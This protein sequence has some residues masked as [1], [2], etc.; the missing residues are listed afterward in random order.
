MKIFSA[1]KDYPFRVPLRVKFFNIFRAIFTLS[2]L[3]RLLV[4]ALGSGAF[5]PWKRLVPPL[6]FYETNSI[7]EVA[8]DGI[9]YRLDI[10]RLHGH[11]IY[12]FRLRDVGWD[13]LFK[14]LKDNFYILDVGANIGYLTL[15]FARRCPNGMVYAFEP[16]SDTFTSL[17]ANVGLNNFNNVRLF[18][19][20]IGATQGT[21]ELYKMH[22]RNPGA[23]RILSEKPS[24]VRSETVDISTL[25]AHCENKSFERIDLIKIDVEGF[26][27]FVLEGAI[28]VLRQWRPMLFVELVDDNLKLQGCSGQAVVDFLKKL[29]YS[30]LDAQTMQPLV[31]SNTYYTD[32]ICCPKG[33]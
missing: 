16:D 19:T 17:S 10:S 4:A 29:D 25:D 18:H 2:F 11:S 5:G 21:G 6:Y 7:R 23:N 13:N 27:L 8:R 31:E 12:F 26:E 3:E 33:Q 28:N 15:Q 32:I 1:Y 20:A 14:L 22:E 24:D 30:I 9:R